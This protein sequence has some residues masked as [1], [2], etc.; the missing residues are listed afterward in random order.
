[1]NYIKRLLWLIPVSLIM[2]ILTTCD[3]EFDNPWDAMSKLTP[4]SWAPENLEVERVDLTRARLTW[5]YGDYNI[6]G[7]KL[8]RRL[9]E[10]EW[11][12]GY[13][14]FTK[15]D[16]TWTDDNIVP[17]HGLKYYYRLYAFAGDNE[18]DSR[19]LVFNASVPLPGDFRVSML[20]STSVSLSWNYDYHGYG[21]FRLSRKRNE[22]DWQES[23]AELGKDD[24]SYNDQQIDL[25]NNRYHYRLCVYISEYTSE[26]VEAY[27]S[28]PTLSTT[29]VTGITYTS[30]TGGGNVF[31]SGG[32]S[33]TS[34]GITYGTYENPTINGNTVSSGSGTGL[35]TANMTG[36]KPETTYYV[37][38]YATNN[39]GTAYGR[40]E[41][42][43]TIALGDNVV[44]NSLT[45]REWMDRN[46]GASRA[47]TSNN[48]AQAYGDLYQWGR[49]A[50]GHQVRT[51][52]MTSTL[53][54]SNTPGHGNFILA[55]NSPYDWR[56]PRNDNLWQGVNGTNNPCPLG[57]RLPTKAEWNEEQQSWSSNNAAGAFAS[58]LK[59]SVAGSR[60]FRSGSIYDAGSNGY[61]WSSAVDGTY[62]RHLY[63]R[64]SSADMYSSNRARGRSVRCLK[65]D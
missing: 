31:S 43:K 30:A 46:L 57:Y 20:S 41:S 26:N 28:R 45:G 37:R 8:D 52:G 12:F 50:D 23:F 10:G 47:A 2:L 44:I 27:I 36:L 64:G 65:D 54:N 21:G 55:Q 58:P 24:K 6:E 25:V 49:A 4:G 7:F 32:S 35:F 3:R 29:Q 61:Y 56:S 53:S 16:R 38:A 40:Q 51:S 17:E 63:F 48:D 15:E 39:A 13:M 11:Q 59:L 62:S 5:T 14:V 19:Y 33:V 1:M 22:E 60:N 9:G 34:R 18:S 42:F